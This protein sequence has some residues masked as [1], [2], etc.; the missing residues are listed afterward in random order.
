[1]LNASD[2]A[3]K[4]FASFSVA[5]RLPGRVRIHIPTLERLPRRWYAHADRT[6]ALIALREGVID[7]DIRP[8]TGNVVVRYDPEQ[9]EEA[10]VIE[11]LKSLVTGFLSIHVESTGDFEVD[12]NRR[13]LRLKE[14]L[15]NLA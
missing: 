4:V 5:H 14:W 1:M 9:I 15:L 6:A 3:L 7:A 8:V 2:P 11:W 12:I 10:Q 13:F